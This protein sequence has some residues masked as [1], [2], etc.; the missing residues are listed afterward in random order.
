MG[1][2]AV[3]THFGRC[4]AAAAVM[5]GVLIGSLT[6]AALGNL[7]IFNPAEHTARGIMKRESNRLL[8][9]RAAANIIALWWRRRRAPHKVTRNQRK[10]DLFGYRRDFV[11]A[12]RVLKVDLEECASTSAKINQIV[13]NANEVRAILDEIGINLMASSAGMNH[14]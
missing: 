9:I 11:A 4:V 6:T 13:K 12:E 3:A 10:M 1:N 14:H 7:M 2:V 8:Y 5:V